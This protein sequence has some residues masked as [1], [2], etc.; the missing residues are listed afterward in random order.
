MT[1]GKWDRLKIIFIG[2][3]FANASSAVPPTPAKLTVFAAASLTEVVGQLAAAYEKD[4]G[5]AIKTSFASSGMLARQIEAGAPADIFISADTAWMDDLEQHERLVSG[6][7]RPLLLN[8]LV[9]VA[10]ADSAIKLK[11]EPH[12]RIVS[13]LNGGRIA[14]AEPD[15]VP[16]GRYAR[17]AFTSFEVWKEL[18]PHILRAED[19]RAALAWV[20][21]G[22]A[23]LGVVY[24]TDAK[25]EPRVRVVDTFPVFSYP[26]IVY[27]MAQV[28]GA[29]RSAAGFAAYLESA[30][31]R[32]VFIKYGFDLP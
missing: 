22:E 21:R 10:P 30:A 20:A 2:C 6:S 27:P 23:P 11:L 4:S 14:L 31:A 15:T 32:A 3:V 12:V 29:S 28:V 17:V 16:A 5:I 8:R 26:P 19:V 18:E 25:I 9:L 13:A 24:A 1:K 7:R